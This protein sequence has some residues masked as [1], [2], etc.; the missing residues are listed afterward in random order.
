VAAEQTGVGDGR[1]PQDRHDCAIVGVLVFFMAARRT[2]LAQGL[3]ALAALAL[4]ASF[5]QAQDTPPVSEAAKELVGAWEISN[6]DRDKRCPVTFSLDS[7]P[8]GFKLELDPAC[9]IA[10]LKDVVAWALGPKDVLR[11]IDAGRT[12][13]LEFTE[14]ESGLYE[15]ERKGEGLY[16]MQTQAALKA[17]IRNPEQIFG[18]WQI[19]RELDQPL[20]RLTLSDASSDAQ[21]TFRIVVKPGCD[22]R[23]TGFGLTTWRLDRGQLVLS[24]RSGTWRFA[25]SDPTTWERMPLSTD[26]LLLM[27]Q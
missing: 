21:D 22:A 13:V 25:E 23:I 16:F 11:L 15:G 14:V 7:A 19:V 6:S 4:A 8:G 1:C 27:K 26:P 9:L 18:E 5:A 2:I 3:I 12:A 20:C 17:E 24:G 10:P